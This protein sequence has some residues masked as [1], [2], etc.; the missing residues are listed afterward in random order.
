M[1]KIELLATHFRDML[2]QSKD[3]PVRVKNMST[4]HI[5]AVI[6]TLEW[7]I[8]KNSSYDATH[9]RRRHE[10]TKKHQLATFKKELEWRD[11]NGLT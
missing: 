3:G 9:I 6:R 5:E 4:G 2:W 1:S 10:S 7:Q 11:R 8:Q